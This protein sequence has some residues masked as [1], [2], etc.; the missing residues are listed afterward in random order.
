MVQEDE[1]DGDVLT[2][3]S[4]TARAEAEQDSQK[5]TTLLS[6][7]DPSDALTPQVICAGT[8][9]PQPADL[10]GHPAADG[11][12]GLRVPRLPIPRAAI[13]DPLRVRHEPRAQD[14]R[15]AGV[16]DDEGVLDVVAVPA[17][18]VHDPPALVGMVKL[19]LKKLERCKFEG[20]KLCLKRFV[21]SSVSHA[22]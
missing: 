17:P 7:V 11:D 4:P 3:F 16:L 19:C 22:R 20:L 15:N 18:V 14:L 8:R 10:R 1:D 13:P 9:R 21:C 5:A 6:M 12:V 2:V